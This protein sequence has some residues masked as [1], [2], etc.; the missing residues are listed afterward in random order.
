MGLN[1]SIEGS[2]PSFSASLDWD[3][4]GACA[5]L[6]SSSLAV[7]LAGCGVSSGGT[8]KGSGH[9]VT[10]KRSVDSFSSIELI[11][12]ATDRVFVG[13]PAAVTIRGDDN[14]LR[15]IRT[16]VRDGVLVVSSKHSYSSKHDL[17]VEI[18]TP[19]LD[20]VTL[21]GAGTFS[22]GGI[23][24]TAFSLDAERGR[25]HDL[26]GTTGTLDVTLSGA[27]TADLSTS[28]HRTRTHR[29]P[30]PEASTCTSTGSLDAT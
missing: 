5:G 16:Y 29:S 20:A 30:A 9:V 7:V 24:A 11:G 1:G 8:T 18:G 10:E 22:V 27:G 13:K 3:R 21:T 15:L 2:N 6:R 23:H 12:A 26:A 19:A 4:T 25:D 17:R 14:I 28:W